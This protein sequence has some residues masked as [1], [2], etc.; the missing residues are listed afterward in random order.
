M[1]LVRRRES[2]R[3]IL[4]RRIDAR[5][6]A[7]SL[8][9]Q[10]VSRCV[11]KP[12]FVP[13]CGNPR[14]DRVEYDQEWGG[15]V[16]IPSG[17]QRSFRENDY[18]RQHRRVKPEALSQF[19]EPRFV[20]RRIC[21]SRIAGCVDREVRSLVPQLEPLRPLRVELESAAVVVGSAIANIPARKAHGGL[22]GRCR[23]ILIVT[24]TTARSDGE[25]KY[26]KR[27]LH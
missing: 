19:I 3:K 4:V 18:E 22:S 27:V 25:G 20:S 8:L 23:T 11:V 6:A 17:R 12:L 1:I 5:R 24:A 14:T 26:G 10:I 16:L 9:Q 21:E 7:S 15:E 2:L 13:D